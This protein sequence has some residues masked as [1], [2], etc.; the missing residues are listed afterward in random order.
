M[1]EKKRIGYT[2]SV[3]AQQYGV[4]PQ[5]LRA[6]E[7]EGL[8]SPSRTEGN[9]RLY[10][11]EDLERLELILTLTRELKVNLAGVEV[12]LHMR[13]KM[14]QMQREVEELVEYLR[15]YYG[16]DPD[17]VRQRVSTAL[18]PVPPAEIVPVSGVE[19]SAR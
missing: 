7:R 11:D 4:H 13:Q 2:I 10:T 19:S 3:V 17:A 1:A 5:T 12:I 18:V 15:L 16:I 6:Y 8:L 14:E 9:T